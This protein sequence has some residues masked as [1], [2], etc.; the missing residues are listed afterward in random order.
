MGRTEL[1]RGDVNVRLKLRTVLMLCF[2]WGGDGGWGDFNVHMKLHTD[3][4]LRFG[5]GWG[6]VM[7]T[8]V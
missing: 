4:T 2:G 5:W 8:F 3:L 6:V 7:L 1:E